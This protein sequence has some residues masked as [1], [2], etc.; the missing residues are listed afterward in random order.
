VVYD[1]LRD[2]LTRLAERAPAP[3]DSGRTTF[4]LPPR[5][6][7]ALTWLTSQLR[8]TQ[9][10]VLAGLPDV[11]EDLRATPL[12]ETLGTVASG[13]PVPPPPVPPPAA[14]SM[15][16]PLLAEPA[17]PVSREPISPAVAYLAADSSEEAGLGARSTYVLPRY[18]LERLTAQSES[19]GLPRDEVVARALIALRAAVEVRQ[20]GRPDVL[21]VLRPRVAGLEREAGVAAEAAVA[22]PPHDP[23]RVNLER[24]YTH[25]VEA[26]TALDAEQSE[27]APAAG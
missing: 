19:L 13:T 25:L 1:P 3:A 26:R 20:S 6:A 9:K 24:A 7:D 4:R 22:L 11:V 2:R 15:S 27:R 21:R 10:D 5:A 14:M 17:A 12:W 23:I 18:A 16:E 8:S